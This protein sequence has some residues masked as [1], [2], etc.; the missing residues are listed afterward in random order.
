MKG[1]ARENGDEAMQ[2]N[3][4]AA[5]GIDDAVHRG[6]RF[7]NADSEEDDDA[8]VTSNDFGTPERK[9]AAN[10]SAGGGRNGKGKGKAV[11]RDGEDG[12]VHGFGNAAEDEDLYG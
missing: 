4:G 8:Y 2:A 3:G 7:V 11:V 9:G 10:G 12:G 1:K 5:G 6:T